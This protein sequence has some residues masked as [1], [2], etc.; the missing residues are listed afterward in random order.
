VL[1]SGGTGSAFGAYQAFNA[2][3]QAANMSGVGFV[4]Y[5]ASYP[6]PPAE[7]VARHNFRLAP[8]SP[9]KG[10]G[11]DGKDPGADLDA[12]EAASGLDLT[13]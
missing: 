6:Y 13:P 11:L 2:F 5:D 1:A 7:N 8:T 3:P 12:I 10:Y 9:F 4:S